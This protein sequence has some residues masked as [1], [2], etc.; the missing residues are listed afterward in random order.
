M[1]KREILKKNKAGFKFSCSH[2]CHYQTNISIISSGWH[3][4]PLSL[5]VKNFLYLNTWADFVSMLHLS[6]FSVKNV[7]R[8]LLNL[9]FVLLAAHITMSKGTRKSRKNN[10]GKGGLTT[11]FCP[12]LPVKTTTSAVSYSSGLCVVDVSEPPHLLK[13]VL[14]YWIS[15]CS[16]SL[17]SHSS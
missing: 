5:K 16:V 13:P 3:R 9:H 11:L 12:I 1:E 7:C 8:S 4:R 14:G 6:V 17:C 2:S 10:D 15:I